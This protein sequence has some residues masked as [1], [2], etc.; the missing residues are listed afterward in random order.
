MLTSYLRIAYR[1]LVRNRFTSAINIG[2]FAIGMAVAILIGLWIADELSF[3][4]VHTRHD[5]I[6]A[7][8]QNQTISGGIQTW[9][10]QAMQLAPALS[11][12]YGGLFK[13]VV[14]DGGTNKLLVT[15]GDKEVKFNGSYMDPAIIDL[16]SLHM[17]KGNSAALQDLSSVIISEK[18]ARGLFG[19]DDPIG[20]EIKVDNNYLVKVTGVYADLP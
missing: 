19:A 2:G 16:L 17:L 5:R 6:A 14:R 12:D 18:M 7:V 11:K 10:G 4:H 3:D 8:L 1:N 20:K 15:F 13:Y 9:R